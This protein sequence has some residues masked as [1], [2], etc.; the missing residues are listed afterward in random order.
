MAD[1]NSGIEHN[2]VTKSHHEWLCLAAQSI[3]PLYERLDIPAQICEDMDAANWTA[4]IGIKDNS[5]RRE[6]FRE[7]RKLYQE[8]Q[9]RSANL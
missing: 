1:Q 5:G 4:G 6:V 8:Q 7:K 9:D 3:Q 2:G